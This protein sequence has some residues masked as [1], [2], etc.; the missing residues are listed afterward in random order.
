MGRALLGVGPKVAN[1]VIRGDLGWWTMKGRSDLAKLRFWGKILKT[2]NCQ[3][4][5]RV[6]KARRAEY[7]QYNNKKSW[8]GDVHRLLVALGLGQCWDT[9][10]VG[11]LTA[12]IRLVKAKI[13]DREERLEIKVRTENKAHAISTYQV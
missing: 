4:I 3:L 8:C 12:W 13:A 10:T 1:D 2:A 9:E 6:Y 7:I 5:H 11:E